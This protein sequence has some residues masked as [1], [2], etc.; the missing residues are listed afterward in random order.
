M[1]NVW[2]EPIKIKVN[3]KNSLTEICKE[4]FKK[5]D[6]YTHHFIY[7][8]KFKFNEMIMF[9]SHYNA[10]LNDKK[11]MLEVARKERS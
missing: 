6:S 5:N 7:S 10:Y 9:H 3:R 4:S 11:K 8:I 2:Y 1:H